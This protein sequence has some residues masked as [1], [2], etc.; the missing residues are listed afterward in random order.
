MAENI[1]SERSSQMK[2]SPTKNNDMRTMN[3][4]EYDG[5]SY[6]HV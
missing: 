6:I 2:D 3:V 1:R 4:V 5:C